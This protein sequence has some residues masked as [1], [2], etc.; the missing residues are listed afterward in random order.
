LVEK[1]D[2][3]RV[4]TIGVRDLKGLEMWVGTYR[5]MGLGAY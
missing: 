1:E 4:E 5:M 3:M 2:G